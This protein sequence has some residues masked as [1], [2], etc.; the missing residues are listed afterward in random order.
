MPVQKCSTRSPRLCLDEAETQLRVFR[1]PQATDAE[2]LER[3]LWAAFLAANH[4]R[5]DPACFRA[6]RILQRSAQGF[7][8]AWHRTQ[9]G[10]LGARVFFVG[11]E[12]F[13]LREAPAARAADGRQGLRWEF[14]QEECAGRRTV[15]VRLMQ[16]RHVADESPPALLPHAPTRLPV[17][18]SLA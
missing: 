6:W 11:G 14:H 16:R 9:R 13:E 10:A 17:R 18:V 2:R 1:S 3:C 12:R 5:A 8:Q 7:L 15:E 4:T